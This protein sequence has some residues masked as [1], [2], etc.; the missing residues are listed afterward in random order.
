MG[1]DVTLSLGF[2]M[3]DGVFE[4]YNEG[5]DVGLSLGFSLDKALFEG[6]NE[7]VDVGL[8]LGFSLDDGLFEGYNEGGDVGLSLGFSPGCKLGKSLG[9]SE[10][11]R[12][13]SRHTLLSKAS[14]TAADHSPP[15]SLCEFQKKAP[16]LQG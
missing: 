1:G 3:D 12:L 8:S 7:G 4:G 15:V 11:E 6:Y 10:G 14:W 2:S 5:D 9:A 16:P 13:S